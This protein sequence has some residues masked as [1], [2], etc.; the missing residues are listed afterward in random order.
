MTTPFKING[1]VNDKTPTS[2]NLSLAL[3][4]SLPN[5]SEQLGTLP[6]L[7]TQA[8]QHPFWTDSSAAPP[9]A[10]PASDD[11]GSPAKGEPELHYAFVR[12]HNR[13]PQGNEDANTVYSE[14]KT[15]K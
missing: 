14:I 6:L 7:S 8:H 3:G 10:S 11:A 4:C 2:P 12:F 13:K 15:H 5:P 9:A 1:L